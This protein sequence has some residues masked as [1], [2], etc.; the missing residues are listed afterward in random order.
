MSARQARAMVLAA[1]ALI[2]VA[3]VALGAR[4]PLWVVLPPLA[5]VA[6]VTARLLVEAPSIVVAARAAVAD[7]RARRQQRADR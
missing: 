5:G 6:G 2:V 1:D 4:A 3:A 7:A